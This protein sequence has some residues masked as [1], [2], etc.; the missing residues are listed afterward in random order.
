MSPG[1]RLLT[2]SRK[3]FSHFKLEPELPEVA[4]DAEAGKGLGLFA[5]ECFSS[6]ELRP[7]GS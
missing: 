1:L 2:V 3:H 7:R 5:G 4:D 6:V